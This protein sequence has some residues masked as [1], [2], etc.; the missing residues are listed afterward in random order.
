[1][2]GA[3]VFLLFLVVDQSWI[4]LHAKWAQAIVQEITVL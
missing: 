3:K 1:M 4:Y 2:A